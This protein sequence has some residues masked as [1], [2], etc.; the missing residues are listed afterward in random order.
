MQD[1]SELMLFEGY[2][3][4]FVS[5]SKFPRGDVS[6]LFCPLF[7]LNATILDWCNFSTEDWKE[8]EQPIKCEA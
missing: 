7:T 4:M 1:R 3:E 5:I 6:L 8:P 2:T